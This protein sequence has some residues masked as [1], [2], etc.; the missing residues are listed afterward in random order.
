[1]RY[2]IPVSEGRATLHFGQCHEFMLIDVDEDGKVVSK[3]TVASPGHQ[4]G[5]L[6]GWLSSQGANVIITGGMGLTPR[7]LFRQNGIEVVL[8]VMETN[9]EKAAL[10]HF[11]KELTPGQ[12]LCE[13]GDAACDHT[14]PHH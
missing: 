13:H 4:C 9:P 2:A 3:N 6:P 8:G 11:N 7:M 10:A 12:N 5:Y 1:M 14:G